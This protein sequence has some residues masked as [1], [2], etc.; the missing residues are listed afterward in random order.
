MERRSHERRRQERGARQRAR[1]DA[2]M[3]RRSHERRR[4]SKRSLPS[5]SSR[6]FNG[7]PLSR[8]AKGA[9]VRRSATRFIASMER[10]SHERRRGRQVG[11]RHGRVTG[12]NGAPLSRAAKVRQTAWEEP[13]VDLGF[14]GAPL[15]RAAKAI[16][17]AITGGA[18]LTL[19]WSAALTSG[20]GT[21]S[22]DTM[23]DS[24]TA[25]MERRSHERR[26]SRR[27][28]VSHPRRRRFNGAPLSRAAKDHAGTG[29]GGAGGASMER[30]SHERR[31]S[32]WRRARLRPP[33][34]LQWSAALTS[35]E[36]PPMVSWRAP[37]TYH[38]ICE[39]GS[40]TSPSWVPPQCTSTTK[41]LS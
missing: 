33:C 36:G 40:A 31:R 34:S 22:G 3:E 18:G 12:F 23:T 5:G 32:W 1:D 9:N 19:Q 30:R 14:N 15:S 17:C 27:A 29:G 8:A 39:R 11:E 26:R 4:S 7:A 13:V 21:Y 35:G 41:P 16:T 25:S 10:R 38:S 28:V 37:I 20:E 24:E 2:S 6:S